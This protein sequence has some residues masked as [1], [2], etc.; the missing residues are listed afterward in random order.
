MSESVYWADQPPP[1][2]II[3]ERTRNI[4][5][6]LSR[7]LRRE[8]FALV[9]LANA[10]ELCRELEQ[11]PARRVVLLDPDLPGLSDTV[12]LDRLREVAAHCLLLIHSYG[13]QDFTPLADLTWDTVNRN[14]D[15]DTLRDLLIRTLTH[16][17][18]S[19]KEPESAPR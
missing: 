10:A 5:T 15:I 4:R 12:W 8:G 3:A 19:K 11:G 17:A 13:A 14:G 18:K 7:E 9:T 2:L 16:S 6:L 1:P